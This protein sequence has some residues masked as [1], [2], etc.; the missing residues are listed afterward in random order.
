MGSTPLG[1][2]DHLRQAG[3]NWLPGPRSVANERYNIYETF[4]PI[5]N[6]SVVSLRPRALPGR[7]VN[8]CTISI[9]A[10]RLSSKCDQ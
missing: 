1:S 4:G 10:Q 6:V 2:I 5:V 9:M 8:I 3:E 7:V